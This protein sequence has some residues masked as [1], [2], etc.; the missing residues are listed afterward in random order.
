MFTPLRK[1]AS[2]FGSGFRTLFPTCRQAS[3]LQSAALDRSLSLPQRLGLRVHLL[4]CK[5]C[6]RY[7]KQIRAVHQSARTHQETLTEA[8]PQTLSPAA[9]ERI[10]RAL[11]RELK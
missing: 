4:I 3:Q 2:A 1:L 11:S 7:G 5:W 9:R 8:L 6:R 10:Q